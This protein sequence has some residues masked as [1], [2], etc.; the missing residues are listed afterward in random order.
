MKIISIALMLLISGF[1]FSHEPPPIVQEWRKSIENY[2][3]Y[4]VLK[5]YDKAIAETEKL[6]G[7]DP[8]DNEAKFY[9]RYAYSKSNKKTPSWLNEEGRFTELPEGKFYKMLA[10]ELEKTN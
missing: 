5:D 2:Q 8:S 3:T 4:I 9:L 1:V 10:S 7:I 6:L